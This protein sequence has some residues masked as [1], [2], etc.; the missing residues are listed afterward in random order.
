MLGACMVRGVDAIKDYIIVDPEVSDESRSLID[1]REKRFLSLQNEARSWYIRN[2]NA[3][4]PINFSWAMRR[5]IG[6][7]LD[8]DFLLLSKERFPDIPAGLRNNV[9]LVES[10]TTGKDHWIIYSSAPSAHSEDKTWPGSLSTYGEV[11]QTGRGQVPP[12]NKS[13]LEMCSK[14]IR[15]LGTDTDEHP[16]FINPPEIRAGKIINTLPSVER[17]SVLDQS[18]ALYAIAKSINYTIMFGGEFKEMNKMGISFWEVWENI[19][20]MEKD[21]NYTEGDVVSAM[22]YF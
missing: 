10:P 2:S 3:T 12:I 15:V 16:L 9:V 17:E 8:L 5:L 20:A 1:I 4:C 7:G 22:D 19:L 14:R 18:K 11:F 21:S 13:T 6:E